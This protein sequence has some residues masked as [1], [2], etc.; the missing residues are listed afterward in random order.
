ME[1]LQSLRAEIK[2]LRIDLSKMTDSFKLLLSFL[3]NHD[4]IRE[5]EYLFDQHTMLESNYSLSGE[6]LVAEYNLKI[7]EVGQ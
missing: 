6:V 5:D 2:Q 4:I 7:K 3:D 1:E